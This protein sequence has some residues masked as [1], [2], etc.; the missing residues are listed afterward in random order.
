MTEPALKMLNA[1]R[2]QALKLHL[3]DGILTVTLENPAK[4]NAL[5][6]EM[7]A[8]LTLVWE[9]I[10]RDPQVKVVVLTGHGSDFCSGFDVGKLHER[11]TGERPAA[12]VNATTRTAKKHLYGILECEKPVLAKVRGVAYGIGVTMALACDMVFAAPGARFCDPHVKAGMVAGDGGV[13]LWPLLVG[14]HRAKEFLMTGEPVD[15]AAAAQM[16]LIN[17]CVADDELDAR[18]LA[19]ARK[20]RDLPPHAVA[21][22]KSS[23]NTAMKQMGGAAFETSLAYELYTMGTEDFTEATAAFVQKRPPRFH[24][25]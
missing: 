8:E 4:R 3:D 6:P 14:M 25:R 9:D 2:Y 20:L 16:G 19:M 10:W 7:S 12:P 17:H 11:A 13:M 23:L 24:G 5:T 15:A 21:Y 1:E 22:T 18:V